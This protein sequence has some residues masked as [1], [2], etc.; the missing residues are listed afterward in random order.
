MNMGE[1]M[2]EAYE[3]VAGLRATTYGTAKGSFQQIADLWSAY[4]N[5]RA[6]GPLTPHDV[7]NMMILMKVSRS[8][9][10]GH[11]HD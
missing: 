2:L 9:T 3:T 11:H 5:M 10:G 8:A 7:S 6:E 4:L 1:L